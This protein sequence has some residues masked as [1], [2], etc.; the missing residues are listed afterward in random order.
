VFWFGPL[1]GAVLA[2][3]LYEFILNPRRGA[4]SGKASSYGGKSSSDLIILRIYKILASKAKK[5]KKKMSKSQKHIVR[6][7]ASIRLICEFKF[8][9]LVFHTLYLYFHMIFLFKITNFKL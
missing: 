8:F 4:D 2:G 1:L 3:T 7:P 9:S 5:K 6:R